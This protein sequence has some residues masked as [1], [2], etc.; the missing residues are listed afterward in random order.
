MLWEGKQYCKNTMWLI[1]HEDD[2]S[3][4]VSILLYQK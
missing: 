3:A 1:E 2:W 4:V